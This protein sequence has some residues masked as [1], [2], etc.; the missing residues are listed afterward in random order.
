MSRPIPGDVCVLN[1]GGPHMTVVSISSA[2]QLQCMWLD[3]NGSPH[4][5]VFPLV[6]VRIQAHEASSEPEVGHGG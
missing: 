2:D 6:C 4:T 3:D 1:S 5:W